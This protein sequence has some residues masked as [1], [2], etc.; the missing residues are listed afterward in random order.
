MLNG[1][2][3]WFKCECIKICKVL[4]ACESY[5]YIVHKLPVYEKGK[6]YK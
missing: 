5:N 3:T 6:Y 1:L 2:I 4:L